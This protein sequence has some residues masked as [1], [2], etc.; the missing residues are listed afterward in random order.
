MTGPH[1]PDVRPATC[2]EREIAAAERARARVL[3]EVVELAV[4]L[5]ADRMVDELVVRMGAPDPGRTQW[6]SDQHGAWVEE[7]VPEGQPRAQ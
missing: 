7:P 1:A 3:A 5:G 4:S 2:A 6:T